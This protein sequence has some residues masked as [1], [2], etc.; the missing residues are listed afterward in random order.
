MSTR[1]SVFGEFA[2][3]SPGVILQD[4]HNCYTH[5]KRRGHERPDELTVLFD[6]GK[7]TVMYSDALSLSDRA[8]SKC[9][10]ML[11]KFSIGNQSAKQQKKL[12]YK[13][14]GKLGPDGEATAIDMF[15]YYHRLFR[16]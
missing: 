16:C 1:N 9:T 10:K 8:I 3:L 7:R 5:F 4:P 15:N 6:R 13:I 14:S 2:V 11:V 12:F